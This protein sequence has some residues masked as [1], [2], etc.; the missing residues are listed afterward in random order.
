MFVVS[1]ALPRLLLAQR[2]TAG[3]GSRFIKAAPPPRLLT[4]RAAS[5]MAPSRSHDCRSSTD[6]LWGNRPWC[7]LATVISDVQSLPERP[8]PVP[9]PW[10]R[11][12]QGW[13][14]LAAG[15][16]LLLISFTTNYGDDNLPHFHRLPTAVQVGVGLHVAALAVLLENSGRPTRRP[17]LI[18]AVLSIPGERFPISPARKSWP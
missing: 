5:G 12:L 16:L 3:P 15:C 13:S 8:A 7:A 9:Q 18:E 6:L 2:A 4:P 1:A 14:T 17:E 10:L 11:D